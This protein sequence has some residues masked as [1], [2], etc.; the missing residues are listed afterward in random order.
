PVT[1]RLIVAND[2]AVALSDD[3]AVARLLDDDA[4][5]LLPLATALAQLVHPAAGD[6]GVVRARRAQGR[7]A[8][9][10]RSRRRRHPRRRRSKRRG[11]RWAW[12]LG[13]NGRCR[14][15]RGRAGRRTLLFAGSFLAAW[16]AFPLLAALF[17]R[18]L[19]LPFLAGAFFLSLLT[20]AFLLPLLA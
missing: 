10:S 14:G 5:V 3:R 7:P 1:F 6:E 13:G 20:G 4:P 17:A 15:R 19:L 2:R 8:G 11:S 16:L 18:P 12:G 9:G